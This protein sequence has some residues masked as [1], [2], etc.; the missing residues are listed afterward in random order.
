MCSLLLLSLAGLVSLFL[1]L[2]I[3]AINYF[4]LVDGSRKQTI[5][6]FYEKRPEGLP[7]RGI[8]GIRAAMAVYAFFSFALVL[9]LADLTRNVFT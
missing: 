9:Y 8:R 4:V 5:I 1:F 2:L 7:G 6:R 3:S